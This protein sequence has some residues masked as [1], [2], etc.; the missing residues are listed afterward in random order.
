MGC[1]AAAAFAAGAV[2]QDRANQDS[3]DRGYKL[4]KAATIVRS[5]WHL[6]SVWSQPLYACEIQ[7]FACTQSYDIRTQASSGQQW[8]VEKDWQAD[9]AIMLICFWLKWYQLNAV[10]M[11]EWNAVVVWKFLLTAPAGLRCCA[12]GV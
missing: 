7:V 8:K 11:A 5:P 4:R 6:R 1:A 2:L 12:R 9:A 10:R 3:A